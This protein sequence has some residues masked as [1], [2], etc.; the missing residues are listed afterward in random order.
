MCEMKFPIKISTICFVL[1]F[2]LDLTIGIQHYVPQSVS[3]TLLFCVVLIGYVCLSMKFSIIQ[4]KDFLKSVVG[5]YIIL[6]LLRLINDF[7]LHD[8]Y[9]F[10]YKSPVTLFFF[11]FNLIILPFLF[12]QR[13]ALQIDINWLNKMLLVLLGGFLLLSIRDNLS[14]AIRA[15]VNDRYTGYGEID[16]I[17]YGH[18][19]VSFILVGFSILENSMNRIFRILSFVICC[20]LGFL[21]M[22]FSGSRGPFV[23]LCAV[24]LYRYLASI[25]SF[26][27]VIGMFLV[28]G[29]VYFFYVDII[30]G[31]NNLLLEFK[32]T[33][34]SRIVESV[35]DEMSTS[36]RDSLLRVAF[37]DFLNNPIFGKSYLL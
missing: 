29:L 25:K 17:Y 8:T 34:F 11:V 33:S 20:I 2:L 5:I 37:D 19:G 27:S 18:L 30:V 12:Y 28:G 13:Y 23:A 36:G 35:I 16:I 3:K 32:I 26:R 24:L 14:G 21:A 9:F 22:A 10:M 6:L 31:I 7:V 4:R 1:I 15:T